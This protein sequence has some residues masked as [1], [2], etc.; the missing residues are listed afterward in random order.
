MS[1]LNFHISEPYEETPYVDTDGG[2]VFTFRDYVKLDEPNKGK[3]F[4]V[5]LFREFKSKKLWYF[6]NA[7][8]IPAARYLQVTA[9]IVLASLD[10]S[11]EDMQLAFE[12]IQTLIEGGKIEEALQ[13]TAT[14]NSIIK[15][16]DLEERYLNLATVFLFFDDENPMYWDNKIAKQKKIFFDNLP[17]SDKVK[18]CNWAA[19]YYDQSISELLAEYPECFTEGKSVDKP[20]FEVL[21][22]IQQKSKEMDDFLYIASD[23]SKLERS[24]MLSDTIGSVYGEMSAFFRNYEKMRNK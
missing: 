20:F 17:Q 18:I 19:S 4:L 3:T 12:K 1:N 8:D 9:F 24:M 22:D 16:T 7:S 5:T 15:L 23:G 14:C 13:L 11:K 6:S 10:A 21:E 2:K